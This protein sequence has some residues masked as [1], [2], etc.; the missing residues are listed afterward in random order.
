MYYAI[1]GI[2]VSLDLS[3]CLAYVMLIE[4][5]RRQKVI[6]DRLIT[7]KGAK[8]MYQCFHCGAMA[9][10][11]DSDFTFEEMGYDGEGVV[12]CCHC[13]NCGAEIEY[14][15]AI[16]TEDENAEDKEDE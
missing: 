2:I 7:L 1:I 13:N 10:S 3:L 9:V 16:E 4:H 5:K 11:W 6:E 15:V 12:N 8:K 14:R